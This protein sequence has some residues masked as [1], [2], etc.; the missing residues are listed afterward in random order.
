MGASGPWRV[1]A[2]YGRVRANQGS[3]LLCQQGMRV[4]LAVSQAPVQAPVHI[5][6]TLLPRGFFSRARARAALFGRPGR[7]SGGGPLPL[8]TLHRLSLALLI[9]HAGLRTD[10]IGADL[11][12]SAPHRWQG[13]CGPRRPWPRPCRCLRSWR[14]CA[15]SPRRWRSPSRRGCTTR[16]W[17]WWSN[18]ARRPQASS[19]SRPR[20]RPPAS[21]RGWRSSVSVSAAASRC[22]PTGW[23]RL[24]WL[25]SGSRAGPREG[26]SSSQKEPLYDVII[27]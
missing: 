13:R 23:S 25:V 20:G 2:R 26:P 1:P 9:S 16:W 15:A 3:Q 22:R 24:G 12:R 8:E 4:L 27:R 11:R 14:T 18:A 17:R 5:A 19:P 7:R 21:S 6:G 10:P